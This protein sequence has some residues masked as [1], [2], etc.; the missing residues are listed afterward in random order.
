MAI[1]DN[2]VAIQRWEKKNVVKIN[3]SILWYAYRGIE[4]DLANAE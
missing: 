4:I 1:R 3:E 2:S